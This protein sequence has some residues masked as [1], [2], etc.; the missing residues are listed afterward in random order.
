MLGGEV[1][2]LA[3]TLQD[4]SE[5]KRSE[6]DLRYRL[7][8]EELVASISSRFVVLPPSEIDGGIESA[9]E[10]LGRFIDADRGQLFIIS[11]DRESEQA[12]HR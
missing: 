10:A 12:R 5:R 6:E 4:I 7:E 1:R 9:L 8:F 11:E 3:G 2:R